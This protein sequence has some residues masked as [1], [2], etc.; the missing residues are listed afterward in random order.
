MF[1]LLVFLAVLAVLV[2]S[3]EWGHFIVARIQ[4]IKV[5]E[6]GFGFPPR[7]F[8]I[9]FLKNSLK[10]FEVVWGRG[11]RQQ[12]DGE[13][14]LYSVNVIPLGGFVRIKG[15]DARAPEANDMD[16][17]VAKKVWQKAMVLLAGVV[18]NVVVA[19]ILLS[20][21]FMIGFPAVVAPD[22]AVTG[23]T[24]L[25]VLQVLPGKPAEAAGVI[26]GD[27]IIQVGDLQKPRL[28]TLQEYINAHR[29]EE[30]TVTLERNGEQ[31]I[32]KIHPSVYADSGRGGI[33]VALTEVGFTRYPFFKAIYQGVV[34]TGVYLKEI[35]FAF[36]YLFKGLFTGAGVGGAVAGPVGVAVMTG[37]VARLGLA[38]LLQF[39]ALLSLNLAVLN[40][41]PIPALDGGRLLFV[42]VNWL[43]GRPIAPH[44]EQMIH[45]VS[46]VLLMLLVVGVT[47]KDLSAFWSSIF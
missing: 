35:I 43:R 2:L 19:T 42:I 6:F 44:V 38:Y 15:E 16:S 17:F 40:I 28:T 32:K 29:D 25:R 9:R 47:V 18:M 10:H 46:F 45:T 31:I 5:E 23:P 27:T 7:L 11:R 37:E 36:G 14:T 30:I 4:G 12:S 26:L 3:H 22:A 13:G 41:L 39:T 8:G 21:G 33:G 1:T 24:T 34:T 20:V